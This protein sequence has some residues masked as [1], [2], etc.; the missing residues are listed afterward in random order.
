MGS[1]PE[2][3]RVVKSSRLH[4]V[5]L[6]MLAV[7][8]GSLGVVLTVLICG[9]LLMMVSFTCGGAKFLNHLYL[10]D[11]ARVHCSCAHGHGP[12]PPGCYWP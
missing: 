5:V 2:R 9:F 11:N 8:I 12:P 7:Y 10:A 6:T 3:Q 1:E 4:T